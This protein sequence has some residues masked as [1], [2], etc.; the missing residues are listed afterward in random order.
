MLGVP[1]R[2]TVLLHAYLH[3]QK[4]K[5]SFLIYYFDVVDCRP[6]SDVLHTPTIKPVQNAV[7]YPNVSGHGDDPQR[8]TTGIQLEQGGGNTTDYMDGVC[9]IFIHTTAPFSINEAPNEF[10]V[11]H[12]NDNRIVDMDEIPLA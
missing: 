12:H 9:H 2:R 3:T 6:F 1:I 8:G 4:C 5:H 7:V 10:G 11:D